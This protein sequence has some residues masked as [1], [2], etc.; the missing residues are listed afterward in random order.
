MNSPL[1]Q[2][3]LIFGIMSYGSVSFA[4]IVEFESTDEGLIIPR[5]TDTSVVTTPEAGMI[6]FQINN[7]KGLYMHNGTK[8]EHLVPG[9]AL[10]LTGTGATSVS[11]TYPNFDISS[12]DNVND[13]DASTTNEIQSLSLSGNNLD[14]SLGGGS[15]SLAPFDPPHGINPAATSTI[16][17][18]M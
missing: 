13:A 9:G 16:I 11:G 18:V 7:P 5:V 2:L 12:T 10:M 17:L 14:L 1:F 4:Q 3:L 6:I 8:W 15:V